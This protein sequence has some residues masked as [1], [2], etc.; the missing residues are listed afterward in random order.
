MWTDNLLESKLGD[1]DQTVS[2]V[3]ATVCKISETK[4]MN[5]V[6]WPKWARDGAKSINT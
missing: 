6:S 3:K 4:E 5:S 2:E 1:R